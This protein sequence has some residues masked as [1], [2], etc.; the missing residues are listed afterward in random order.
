MI[1]IKKIGD[2]KKIVRF[3]ILSFQRKDEVIQHIG[4]NSCHY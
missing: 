3:M 4:N 2:I 1:L